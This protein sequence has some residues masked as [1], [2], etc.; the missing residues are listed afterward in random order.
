MLKTWSWVVGLLKNELIRLYTLARR[1][2]SGTRHSLCRTG[3]LRSEGTTAISAQTS[4]LGP[5]AAST[6]TALA[7]TPCSLSGEWYAR[8]WRSTRC[9]GPSVT[10]R[11]SHARTPIKYLWHLNADVAYTMAWLC[12]GSSCTHVYTHVRLCSFGLL[13]RNI[14]SMY[15]KHAHAKIWQRFEFPKWARNKWRLASCILLFSTSRQGEK[16]EKEDVEGT[17]FKLPTWSHGLKMIIVLICT[18][19]RNAPMGILH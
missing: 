7:L 6:W 5:G 14:E 16:G 11:N 4:C 1:T 8:T 2:C 10:V 13:C 12:A 3:T 19:L 15:T 18:Q 17:F 9:K